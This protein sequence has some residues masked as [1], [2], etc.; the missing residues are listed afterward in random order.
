MRVIPLLIKFKDRFK[1]LKPKGIDIMATM[2]MTNKTALEIALEVLVQSSHPDKESAMEKIQN[3]IHS[4][5]KKNSTKSTKLT[6]KQTANLGIGELVVQYL[7]EH[8][9]EMFT[10]TQL[11]KNVE[12]LPAEI[13]N[14]KMTAIFR[15]ESV[16]PYFTRTMDKG[17]ALFQYKAP[18]V[19]EAEDEE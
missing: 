1:S 7:S 19:E 14:Q 18:S 15:L 6:A 3:Q 17:K 13:T 12:G 10:I 11:M 8:P 9:N 2:K 16:K 5:E 4:L